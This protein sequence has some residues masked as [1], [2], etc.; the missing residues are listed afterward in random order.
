M[1]L[2]Q[3]LRRKLSRVTSSGRYIPEIDGLRFLAIMPVLLF[4][5]R[6]FLLVKSGSFYA[7]GPE[8]DPLARITSH[9]HYGVQLFFVISGFVLALPFAAQYLQGATPVKLKNYYLRRLTRLEPPYIACMLICFGL[10]IWIGKESARDLFS[11]L[12]AGLFYSHSIVYGQHNPLN[13]ITWSLEV[14]I[15]FYLLMPLLAMLLKVKRKAVRRSLLV[16][17]SMM[18]VVC[19][20]LYFPAEGRLAMSIFNYLQYFF[21]GFLLADIYLCDWME[22][23]SRGLRWDLLAL[24]GWPL[25]L[26]LMEWPNLTALALPFFIFWLFYAV[27]RGVYVRRILIHPL[28]TVIGGMCYTIYLIHFQVISLGGRLFS[29]LLISDRFFINYMIELPLY[30]FMIL[31]ASVIFFYFIEKPCM[32]K[33]WPRRLLSRLQG[34]AMSRPELEKSVLPTTE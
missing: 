8:T 17:L 12:L 4:H 3:Q 15:Q 24:V 14:E 19:Q 32:K 29:P 7:S 28:L 31:S 21:I 30:L 10:F 20:A 2:T 27:F 13:L 11:H 6:N 33:G 16:L 18:L 22:N 23:P 34:W 9:G 1:K 25:L 5:V 26:V